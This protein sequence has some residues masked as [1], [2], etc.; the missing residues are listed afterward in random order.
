M[1]KRIISACIMICLLCTGSGV[2]AQNT[3]DSALFEVA[4]LGIMPEIKE[5]GWDAAESVTR[6]EFSAIVVRMIGLS[7][8]AFDFSG[9]E[10]YDVSPHHAY[11]SSV[12]LVT[13]LGLMSGVGDGLFNPEGSLTVTQALKVV[14]SV[15]GY[16]VSAEKKGGWPSGYLS[17]GSQLGLLR[18]VT[19]ANEISKGDLALLIANALDVHLLKEVVSG[20]ETVYEID[21]DTTLRQSLTDGTGDATLYKREGIVL[22]TAYSYL[23]SEVPDLNNDEVVIDGVTYKTGQSNAADFLGQEVVFYAKERSGQKPE[24]V[25]VRKS[26]RTEITRIDGDDFLYFDASRAV[27]T[28]DAGKEKN[29]Q[30][31]GF[32]FLLNGVPI[33]KNEALAITNI[34]GRVD[35]IVNSGADLSCVM[36]WNYTNHPVSVSQK[37]LVYFKDGFTLNG[38]KFLNID[39]DETDVKFV[40]LSNEGVIVSPDDIQADDI[41]SIYAD[42]KGSRYT[43]YVSNQKITGTI[44]ML[45]EDSVSIDDTAYPKHKETKLYA[46][47]GDAVVLQLDYLGRAAYA[48]KEETKEKYGYIVGVEKQ[49]ALGGTRAKIVQAKQVSFSTEEQDNSTDD[50]ESKVDV[51]VLVCENASIGV[52][53]FSA[54]VKINGIRYKNSDLQN[55]LKQLDVI[56]FVTNDKGQIGSIETPEFAGGSTTMRSKY[57]VYDK[58]FG[59]STLFDGFAIDEKTKL[60]SIPVSADPSDADYMVKTVVNVSGNGAG[61]LVQGYDYD[62]D[63]KK[64]G[65]VVIHKHMSADEV[66]SARF[67]ANDPCVVVKTATVYDEASESEK[68]KLILLE[69]SGLKEYVI[70]E[71]KSEN[72][73]LGT[74]KTGDLIAYVDDSND[75]I[76]NAV[77]IRSMSRVGNGIS[78]SNAKYGYTEL[79]GTVTDISFDEVHSLGYKLVDTVTLDVNGTERIVNIQHRN[80]APVVYRYKTKSE[81]A[82]PA[83]LSEVVPGQDKLH[84]VLNSSNVAVSC[85][86]ISDN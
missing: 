32:R 2:L 65:L 21:R 35:V 64:C 34:N 80:P 16:S 66:A 28:D 11:A 48:E 41:L 4:S 18:G 22:A 73:V 76:S 10:F 38:K 13:K 42:Q 81:K 86:L 84:V 29:I 14:T 3:S 47:V 67:G 17:V 62:A 31:S 39:L 27:Y 36:I 7:D 72:A 54:N 1:L 70:S 5:E 58:V 30:V 52:Y 82:A 56:R 20:G 12:E 77:F 19:S 85:V 57:S 40:V 46:S 6:A 68:L 74:L 33:T 24:I 23:I 53:E 61:Y 83:V 26:A 50:M 79:C 44:T 78:S 51:P 71:L 45:D 55:V 59:G 49:N 15:L 60:I 75:M 9:N 69:K 43:I 8:A 63:T 25:S 37:G